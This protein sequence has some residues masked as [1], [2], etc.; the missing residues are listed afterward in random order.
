M[1]GTEKLSKAIEQYKASLTSGLKLTGHVTEGEGKVSVVS[2][3]GSR[4]PISIEFKRADVMEIQKGSNDETATIL[5]KKDAG[6]VMIIGGIVGH[7][8]DLPAGMA[9]IFEDLDARRVN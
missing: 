6:Y 3:Y 7:E 5:V 4:I 2:K 1:Q 9:R 8:Q